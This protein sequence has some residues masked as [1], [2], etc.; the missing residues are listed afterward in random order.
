MKLNEHLCHIA[1][2][3]ESFLNK[4]E[5]KHCRSFIDA[6]NSVWETMTEDERKSFI[7]SQPKIHN[8]MKELTRKLASEHSTALDMFREGDSQ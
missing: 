8:R 6:F 7:D 5:V 2:E 4:G 3:A 1:R